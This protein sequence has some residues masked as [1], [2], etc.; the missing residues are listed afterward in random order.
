MSQET[1]EAAA[2]TFRVILSL[3]FL[4]AGLAKLS[5]REAFERG[6]VNYQVL[7]PG[8]SRS[9]AQWLPFL[10]VLYGVLLAL[11][12]LQSIAA[13]GLAALIAAFTTAI[14]INLARGR[15]I[16][17]GCFGPAAPKAITWWTVARNV[18]LL[19]MTLTV[20]LRT[21]EL[22][23]IDAIWEA[24]SSALS[25]GDA[26]G[27]FVFATSAYVGGLLVAEFVRLTRSMKA[28]STWEE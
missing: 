9:V 12:L 5:D 16:D 24:Q 18:L 20:A 25:S 7:P 1:V 6:V 27:A 15:V 11:G 17:C 23:S 22:L 26:L 4:R 19:G 13:L 14:A 21:P 3:L 28:L 10:E 2:L 8:V